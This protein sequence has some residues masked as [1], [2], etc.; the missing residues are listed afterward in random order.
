MATVTSTTPQLSDEPTIRLAGIEYDDMVNGPG[1]R[2][3]VF[4]QGCDF[5]C[6][7]CHNPETWSHHKGEMISSNELL[8]RI[9]KDKAVKKVTWSG[10]EATLQYQQILPVVQQLDYLKYDQM[11]YTGHEAREIERLMAHD[12][13]FALFITHMD[14]VVTGRYIQEQRSL[15]LRFRGSSNQ[16][17]MCPVSEGMYVIL[18]DVTQ[19]WDAGNIS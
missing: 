4:L 14:Y 12:D 16:R 3:T 8:A 5:H 6:P 2:A 13:L 7:G 15:D 19:A 1:L 18:E 11:L 17:V 9:L 10:G